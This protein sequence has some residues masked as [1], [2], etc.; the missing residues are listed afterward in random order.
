M[1]NAPAYVH[2]AFEG[3][4]LKNRLLV[5]NKTSHLQEKKD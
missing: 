3:E 2:K 4:R 5:N 1:G